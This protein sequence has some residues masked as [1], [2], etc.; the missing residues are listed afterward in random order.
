MSYPASAAGAP[1]MTHHDSIAVLLRSVVIG[2]TAFL[3]LVD[4]FATQAILPSLTRAYSVTPAAMGFAVNSSTIGMAVAGLVVSL[5]SRR[6]DRR[7][8]ILISLAVLAIPTALLAVA[9]DLTTFTILRIAQGLCMASAFT[10]TLAYLGEECSAADAAGA[11]AAYITGNVASNLIG[12][13]ISAALVDH[14]GLAWNFYFFAALNLAGALLVYF[15]VARAASMEQMEATAPSPFAAWAEHLGNP[16]LV[17]AFGIGFCILFA[18]IGTFTYVNFVLVRPPLSLGMMQL[19]LV[20]FVFLPSI[21]TTLLAGQAVRRFG[22]RPTL[23]ASLALAAVGLPF[24]LL[25]SLSAVLL[26]MVLVAAGTFFAQATT[27]GYVGRTATGDRGSASGIYLASYF[28]GGLVGTAI[29]GQVFDRLGWPAC[30]AGIGLSLAVAALLAQ[31]L[32]TSTEQAQV[33]NV[34]STSPSASSLR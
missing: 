3:T 17:A 34:L 29:L 26:G 1:M 22:T 2:T 24:L 18:F 7:L 27:T 32:K 16:R 9:P 6:I 8:G 5:C 13:F 4:L 30:V 14:F 33:D 20:Y 10:L 31:R 21:V 28:A 11:F 19:G 15:T 12:R 23:W 25:P